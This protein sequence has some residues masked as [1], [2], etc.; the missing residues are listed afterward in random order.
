M[1]LFTWTCRRNQE[2]LRELEIPQ[3]D[4]LRKRSATPIKKHTPKKAP[5][6]KQEPTRQ[7]A[8]LR[9][10]KAEHV[11]P[12]KSEPSLYRSERKVER[13]DRL[14]DD[15]QQEFLAILRQMP[16]TRPEPREANKQDVETQS[17]LRNQLVDL[18]IRH[19]WATV[20]VTPDRINCSV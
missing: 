2:L 9:G 3:L 17:A 19:E 14:D 7:S 5:K 8:R 6:E 13:I 15:Q 20:K 18:E 11:P 1:F 4:P 16:N 12:P 10:I